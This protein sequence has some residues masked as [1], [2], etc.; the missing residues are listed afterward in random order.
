MFDM[1]V[2]VGVSCWFDGLSVAWVIGLIV[3]II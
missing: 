2:I 3:L 1:L